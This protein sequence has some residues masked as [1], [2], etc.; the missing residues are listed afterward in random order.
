MDGYRSGYEE[1]CPLPERSP[2]LDGADR[3]ITAKTAMAGLLD[4]L[5]GKRIVVVGINEDAILGAMAAADEAGRADD[6]WYSG[7]LA[8]E[9]NDHGLNARFSLRF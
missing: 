7:Q 9:A 1:S 3:L 8:D 4:R 2:V 5:R 6:L